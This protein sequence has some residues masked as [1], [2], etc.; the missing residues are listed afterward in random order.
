MN[1]KKK[2]ANKTTDEFISEAISIHGKKYVYDNVKYNRNSEKVEI[3]CP[4]HG[5]FWQTP[6]A[7]LKRQGCPKCAIYKNSSNKRYSIEEIISKFREKHGERYGYEKVNYVNFNTKVI[8]TCPV[9]SDFEVLPSS[10]CKFGCKKCY[11]E[12]IGEKLKKSLENFKK[13]CSEK[14]NNFFDYSLVSYKN[15]RTKVEIIC[16]LHGSFWQT[17]ESHLCGNGC[18]GCKNSKSKG[19]DKI[20]LFLTKNKIKYIQQYIFNDCRNINPLPFDFYLPDY[21][22]CIEFDGVQHTNKNSYYYRE[23]IEVNDNIKNKY[24]DKNNIKL[25]RLSYTILNNIESHLIKYL[26]NLKI[27]SNKQKKDNFVRKGIE[28]WGYKYNYDRVDYIDSK[29]PVIIGYKGLWYKQTPNKHLQG[30]KIELQEKMISNE[31]FILLSKNIW[32]DR[33]DYS[34]CEYLGT[35]NKIVLYDKE[36]NKWIEQTAKSHLKGHEVI[37]KRLEELIAMCN[38]VHDFKYSYDI[39][40]YKNLNSVIDINCSLHGIFQ[41][42]AA[43]HIYGSCCSKC[44]EYFFNK[45][46]ISFLNRYHIN[47]SKQYRFKECRNKYELPFDFYIP[48]MRVCIDFRGKQNYEPSKYFGGV[49]SY[50]QLLI[51]NRIKLE[52][53]EEHF[54]EL[55]I[56]K[57]DQIEDIHQILWESLKNKIK[58]KI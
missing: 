19:E 33:F 45:N 52:Y 23:D 43:S 21:N 22:I 5:I 27:L 54:I 30:K 1:T 40:N 18:P 2:N 12:I 47:Y 58:I 13:Q 31:N 4:T 55:I 9:H 36:K 35:N 29:T 25:L 46:V 39:K 16:P 10:H 17:P 14:H 15:N 28:L 49:E 51:N 26:T 32:G 6:K 48:S 41:L 57:Y 11:Y 42:K 53:C 8:V 44:D 38:L 37:K 20:S 3:I 34:K 7:H 24:C 50:N 56:V